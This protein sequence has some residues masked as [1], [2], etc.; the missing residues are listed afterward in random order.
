MNRK[1]RNIVLLCLDTVR[2]DFFD[3]YASRISKKSDVE[4]KQCRAVSSWT[5]PSHGSMFTGECPHKHGAHSHKPHFSN[6]SKSDTFLSRMPNY[7]SISVTSNIFLRSANGFNCMFD[8]DKSVV[9]GCWYPDGLT[10]AALD[11]ANS[12]NKY[13]TAL[14]S[15]ATHDSPLKSLINLGTSYIKLNA[16]RSRIPQPIDDGATVVSREVNDTISQADEPFFLFANFM[17]AHSPHTPTL[18]YDSDLYS[19]PWSWTSSKGVSHIQFNAGDTLS[20]EYIRRYR[21]LYA[22]AIEY[23]D[24]KVSLLIENILN[25]TDRET[26]III[27]ADH[28]ENLAYDTD[29]G[30]IGHQA[31]LSEGVLHVPFCIVNPPSEPVNIEYKY[32]S[33]LELGELVAGIATGDIPDVSEQRVVAERIGTSAAEALS[34]QETQYWDRAIRC[35]YDKHNKTVWDSLGNVN[36]YELNSNQPCWQQY[37]SNKISGTKDFDSLFSRPIYKLNESSAMHYGSYDQSLKSR[38]RDLGYI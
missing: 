32:I 11:M 4:F 13:L 28:G 15:A 26:T 2:K 19:A 33:H 16:R 36:R 35:M 18:G 24:K 12:S 37:V 1:S 10:P 8:I 20:E 17:D 34:D 23:L 14:Y 7:T 3:K 9:N 25:N 21:E 27:T 31:S 30:F 5:I 29:N 22:A 38:L 6:V